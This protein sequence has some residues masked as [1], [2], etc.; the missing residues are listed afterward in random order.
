MLDFV[1]SRRDEHDYPV[2]DVP[3]TQWPDVLRPTT[4]P[5]TIL[6]ESQPANQVIDVYGYRI[7]LIDEMAGLHVEVESDDMPDELAKRVVEEIHSKIEQ[8]TGYIYDIVELPPD[9]PARFR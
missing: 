7:R 8:A 1:I 2:F 3:Y 6:E 4:I 9:K 5:A